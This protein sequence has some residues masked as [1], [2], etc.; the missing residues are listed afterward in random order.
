MGRECDEGE[1]AYRLHTHNHGVFNERS[2][3]LV[4][5]IPNSSGQKLG[6]GLFA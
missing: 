1:R 2:R 3:Y 6:E 4:R 5:L